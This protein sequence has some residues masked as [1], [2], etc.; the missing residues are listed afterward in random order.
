MTPDSHVRREI[1]DCCRGH[2]GGPVAWSTHPPDSGRCCPIC[3]QSARLVR[4]NDAP[5]ERAKAASI[6]ARSRWGSQRLDRMAAELVERRR[7]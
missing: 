1:F 5:A 2:G 7:A 6:L 3:E 4:M